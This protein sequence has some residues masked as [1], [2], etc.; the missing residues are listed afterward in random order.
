[1]LWETAA[2]RDISEI[3]SGYG[4]PRALQGRPEG[5]Y[6]FA[7]VG[8]ISKALRRGGF[9]MGSAEN[10]VDD[11]DVAAL[12]ALVFPPGTIVFAK[13]GEAIGKN[14]RA[15]TTTPML[16]DNNV[17]GITPRADLVDAE[18]LMFYLKTLDFYQLASSTI[19]PAL[20]KSVIADLR[21]PLP[22]QEEQRRIVT[23]VKACMER[24]DEIEELTK[25]QFKAENQ[26]LRASRREFLGDPFVIPEGWEE[27]RLDELS[28]VIYGISAAISK[29]KDPQL[30][31][32][33]VRM[34]NISIDGHL[35]L[36]DLRY[37]PI[38]RGKEH[39]FAL[40]PGDL[41][42]NWRSG[43]A[44]HV[45]K[46]ALF[47]EQGLFT[48]ASFILR[49]RSL[50]GR[51][52]NRFL[53]HVLNFMRAEGMFSGQ[54]RMQVNHKLNAA[55]FSAFPIRMPACLDMQED[56][57]DQLD[58]IESFANQISQEISGKLDEIR[59]LRESILLKAF[60]GE[61]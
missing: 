28:E 11:N 16:F 52:N 18:Y 25:G 10:Y 41:L 36:S 8:D 17:M 14:Y 21:V 56:I 30:G 23:R 48:C 38:P 54:S 1:M 5:K 7:K 55:E 33:I 3:H 9:L 43:S 45:G 42:L 50:E 61:L 22:N 58:A 20:R 2:L 34:A 44:A 37:C 47:N 29:N 13:I 53:R 12:R 40:K 15:I 32:P 24:V 19:V 6:P 26:I 57:A 35:N 39:H 46:T 60:A 27:K 31:P 59:A 51:S 4:F 49:I